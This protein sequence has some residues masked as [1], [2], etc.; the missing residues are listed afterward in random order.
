MWL[1]ESGR[2]AFAD[3]FCYFVNEFQ[4]NEVLKILPRGFEL[5][6]AEVLPK[7]LESEEGVSE[8]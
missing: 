5:F 7:K 6:S 2:G 1:L 3:N 4:S 8:S